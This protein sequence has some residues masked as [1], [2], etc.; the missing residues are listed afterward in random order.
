MRVYDTV[1][2][3]ITKVTG[4]RIIGLIIHRIHDL[5]LVE[6]FNVAYYV[7]LECGLEVTRVTENGTI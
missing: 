1:K 7:T 3:Q 2:L 4:N 5:K 6:L